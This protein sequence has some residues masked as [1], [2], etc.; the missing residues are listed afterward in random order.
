M[1]I[2]SC[3]VIGIDWFIPV[4]TISYHC[5]S[6]LSTSSVAMFSVIVM[7]F[8]SSSITSP[9]LSQLALFGLGL[10]NIGLVI[11]LEVSVVIIGR[12]SDSVSGPAS[13]VML[14]V[15]LLFPR[16]I[17]GVVMARLS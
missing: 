17:S 12:W 9:N 13:I 7:L 10:G 14:C 6:A 11:A 16:T 5:S 3:F 15:I 1:L 2:I 4:S 8:I